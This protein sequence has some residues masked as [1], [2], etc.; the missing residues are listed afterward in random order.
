MD[1]ATTV[2][3][4][5]FVGGLTIVMIIV[6]RHWVSLTDRY[7]SL[8]DTNAEN[9]VNKRAA[10]ATRDMALRD[11]TRLQ[12]ELQASQAALVKAKLALTTRLREEQ[13]K[14]SGEIDAA[15]G[16]DIKDLSTDVFG[17]TI[18]VRSDEVSSPT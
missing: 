13:S 3:I 8:C 1:W 6:V 10:E 18:V 11:S 7:V 5:A 16:D 2:G 15:S 17:D 4:S 12:G 14:R 9:V